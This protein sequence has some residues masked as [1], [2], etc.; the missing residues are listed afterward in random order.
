PQPVP[1][2]NAAN[3]V[4]R[5]AYIR[6]C[7]NAIERWNRLIATAGHDFRLRLPSP[8]FRRAIGSWADAS[9]DPDGNPI[10][11]MAWRDRQ[12]DWLPSEADRGF[13]KSVM[14][15]VTEPGHIAGWI[16]PPDRGINEQ[17]LAYDYVRLS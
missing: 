5:R 15:Q 10:D 7:D 12:S 17:P 1:L 3:E 13:V 6:E 16:A 8:R 2:R 9:A 14:Q 11:G 4:T